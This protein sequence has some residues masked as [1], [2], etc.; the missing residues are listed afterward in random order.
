MCSDDTTSRNVNHSRP[1]LEAFDLL[2]DRNL[3][4]LD[5]ATTLLVSCIRD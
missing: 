5:L 1:V 2:Y 3:L 4:V